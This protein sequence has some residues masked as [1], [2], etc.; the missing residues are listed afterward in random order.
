M[1]NELEGAAVSA[2]RGRNKR[3]VAM[4]I[5]LSRWPCKIFSR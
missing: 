5:D 2:T 3:E 1:E 4:R